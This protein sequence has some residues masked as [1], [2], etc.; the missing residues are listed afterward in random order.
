MAQDDFAIVIGLTR[1]PHISNL[2]GPENDAQAFIEWLRSPNGGDIIEK[3]DKKGLVAPA[4]QR[5]FQVLSSDANYGANGPLSEEID[6]RIRNLREAVELYSEDNPRP[7]RLYIFMAGH[8]LSW[9]V[10]NAALL[11]ANA[12]YKSD[13]RNR[14]IPGQRILEWFRDAALFREIVLLM[15]CCRDDY[16]QSSVIENFD[17]TPV[18]S[19]WKDNVKY[20]IGFA[21]RSGAAARERPLPQNGDPQHGLFTYSLLD[22]LRNAGRDAQGRLMGTAL[23]FYVEAKMRELT[24]STGEGAITYIREEPQGNFEWLSPSVLPAQKNI[25]RLTITPPRAEQVRVLSPLLQEI[26]T[27]PADKT[28]DLKDL[29]AG[30][31]CLRWIDGTSNYFTVVGENQNVEIQK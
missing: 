16:A 9:K 24:Q 8:G 20:F 17:W 28:I 31:Y 10:D 12:D 30:N 29:I 26:G 4:D 2:Q 15:D 18:Y 22:G 27:F 6:E 14:H 25:T 13:R 5:I 3:T 23:K 11:A 21:A 7:R 19:T 1:Y